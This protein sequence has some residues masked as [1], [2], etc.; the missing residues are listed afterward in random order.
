M[1]KIAFNIFHNNNELVLQKPNSDFLEL[2]SYWY[3]EFGK[4]A[5]EIKNSDGNSIFS[6]TKKFQFWKWKMCYFISNSKGEKLL[7]QSKNKKNT[8]FEM[9]LDGNFY[10]IKEHYQYKK[11]V[12]KNGEK[13][14]AFDEK[15]TE[16]THKILLLVQDLMDLQF[17]FL[18]YSCLFIGK[19]DF[20]T[21]SLSTQKELEKNLDPWF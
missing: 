5:S 17:I 19:N 12:F 13:I 2:S 7:L 1:K 21:S 3:M 10:T 14:A 11:S 15:D 20:K 6:V 16:N 9:E 18:M 4:F 8:V